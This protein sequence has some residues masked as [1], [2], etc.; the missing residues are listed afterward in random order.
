MGHNCIYYRTD[1]NTLQVSLAWPSVSLAW[2]S[3]WD[4]DMSSI[5]AAGISLQGNLDE[6]NTSFKLVTLLPGG[7]GS[8]KRQFQL[9]RGFF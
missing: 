6:F 8:E 2:P 4:S 3:V 5:P 7:A 1:E 9:P